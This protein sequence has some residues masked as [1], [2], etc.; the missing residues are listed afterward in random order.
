MSIPPL[1]Q[2]AVGIAALKVIAMFVFLAI[3]L[4]I[5]I[6]LALARRS[7]FESQSQIPLHDDS[8]VEP[9]TTGDHR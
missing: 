6:W 8:V 9:R 3:F 5:V 1:L 7:G 2:L 4:G